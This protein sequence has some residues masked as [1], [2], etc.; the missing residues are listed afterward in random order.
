MSK[1]I[2]TYGTF[3]LLHIGHLSLLERARDMG[4][5]LIVG[6]STDKFNL[7]KGKKT[8]IP[9]EQRIEL[10][11]A[12]KCVDVAI[13][14]ETWEQ[15][16]A[17]IVRYGANVFVMGSDWEGRFDDLKDLCDVIYLQRTADISSTALKQAFRG[18]DSGHLNEV[19]KALGVISSILEIYK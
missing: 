4:D 3:D 10:V 12:L 5:R 6:V 11:A 2:I 9:F 7:G 8:F 15:K 13:P 19:Q 1:T 17:D 16:R 14:E 18:L